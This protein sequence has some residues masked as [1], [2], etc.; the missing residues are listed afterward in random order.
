MSHY[1]GRSGN[2][3]LREVLIQID[4]KVFGPPKKI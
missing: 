4:P 2:I 1:K 3:L